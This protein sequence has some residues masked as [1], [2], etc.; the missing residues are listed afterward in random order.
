LDF[1]DPVREL[2]HELEN[3]QEM[4]RSL[5]PQVG[6]VPRLN[7]IDMYGGTLPLKGSVGGDHLI[8]LDFKQRF[9]LDSRIAR[10]AED[11]RTDV[12][13]N[14]RRC[15]RMAGVALLDAAGHRVTDAFLAAMLHQAFLLG[16]IYELDMCGQVTARLFENLNTR[17]YQSSGEHKFVSMVYG[18]ISEDAS[19]RFLSAAHPFP[20]VFS[21]KHDRFMEVGADRCVSSPPLGLVP[22]YHVTDRSRTTSVLGFKDDYTMNEWRL[23][24]AGDILLLYTDGIADHRHAEQAYVPRRLEQVV[25]FVKHRS[26]A[27]IFGAV[28]ADLVAFSEPS[29]DLSL[30]V[31]KRQD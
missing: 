7:G 20:L 15:Q 31:I 5:T 12:I 24:G 23:M 14:L 3:F 8:Y 29:D 1:D 9:D 25:R 27:E 21:R 28:T 2:T 17:F 18:E 26:A 16:A 19:F 13:D 22:S 4:A 30:V 6:D 11:G 10:A